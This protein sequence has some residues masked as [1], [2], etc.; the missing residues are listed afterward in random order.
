MEQIRR[1]TFETGRPPERLDRF[2]ADCIP[3]LTRS[4]LKRLIDEG[5]VLLDDVAGK[6][7]GDLR[8]AR[9][10][11]SSF[12]PPPLPRPFPRKSPSTFFT[13]TRI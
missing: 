1:F 12:R 2:L 7:G 8:G 11:R 6:A 3:E 10:S 9:R 13:K 4:Q 5:R